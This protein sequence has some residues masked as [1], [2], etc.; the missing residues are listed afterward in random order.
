MNQQPKINITF[1]LPTLVAGGAE[2]VISFIAQNINQELFNS[3]LLI[4]G[5]KKDAVYNV[6]NIKVQFLE[7]KRVYQSVFSILFFLNK[8]PQNI[9]LSSI[10]HLNTVMGLISPLFPKTKFIIRE[11][12]VV[13]EMNN[14]TRIEKTFSFSDKFR[15]LM[16]NLSLMFVDNIICQST[17][18]AK[19]FLL[20]YKVSRS[21]ISIINNPI[22]IDFP[23]KKIK[24]SNQ[25]RFI[26]IGRLSEEKGHLRILKLLS[27]LN[28]EFKYIIIG[29]G[30]LKTEIFKTI[31]DYNLNNR[32]TY[33]P[34]TS[35]VAEHIASCDLFLQGSYVEGFPNTA[36]E[37][38]FI[39]TPVL[40][41]NVSGGTKEIIIH[42]K[43]GFLANTEEEYLFYLNNRK[44]LNPLDVRQSVES[45]FNSQK[46][47][48]QY[49][50]L[51][52][53]K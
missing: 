32:I 10:A 36:L 1:I 42:N 30:H 49:E 4:T 25:T 45:R 6:T 17:D 5:H 22:T 18:M 26:T 53:Q 47:I 12:S 19:D 29:D 35:N 46:I 11:A 23:L 44:K 43:N 33:I 9:V 20:V 13:S 3:T 16:A 14:I 39:G 34:Y 37:S 28:F 7:K 51:F 52:I 50:E 41:F 24:N 2:R 48:K 27:K 21:K 38:C 40:A 31:D 8:N 15:S